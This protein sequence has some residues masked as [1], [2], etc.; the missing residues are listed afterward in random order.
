ME[1]SDWRFNVR[2]SNTES[3]LR[4]NVETRSNEGLMLTQTKQLL[5]VIGGEPG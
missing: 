3:L 5:E 1:F 4:L 2:A